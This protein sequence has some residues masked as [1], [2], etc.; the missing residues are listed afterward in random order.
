[1]KETETKNAVFVCLWY[2]HEG[3]CQGLFPLSGTAN[4]FDEP[5]IQKVQDHHDFS[6]QCVQSTLNPVALKKPGP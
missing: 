6:R 4:I 2:D 1:M 3:W 5:A